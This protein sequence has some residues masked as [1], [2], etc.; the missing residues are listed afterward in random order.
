MIL[1]SF[2]EQ[3]LSDGRI[4]H[5]TVA[6]AAVADDVHD[7]VAAKLGAILRRE[8]A[9]AHH[10]VRVFRVNVED[11]NGLAPGHVRSEA[12]RMFLLR[13]CRE[14]NEVIYDDVNRAA[15]RV[16]PQV[17]EVE[18]FRPDA[19]SSESGIAMHDDG[20]HFV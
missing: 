8:F 7:H 3:W 20:Y 18:R 12:R 5:F 15:N 10:S 16:S 17:R 4:V 1:N 11:G 6:V 13:P 14:S 2:I 9:D 19:L